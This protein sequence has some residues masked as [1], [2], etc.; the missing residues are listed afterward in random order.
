MD[1]TRALHMCKTLW[2]KVCE[3]WLRS[4]GAPAVLSM[5]AIFPKKRSIG[6]NLQNR[7]PP[8]KQTPLTQSAY[9]LLCVVHLQVGH[10]VASSPLPWGCLSDG[11][12]DTA[13][14]HT[15]PL[16]P[17][18]A[19]H[20]LVPDSTFGVDREGDTSA[21]LSVRSGVA[22]DVGKRGGRAA[23]A[24]APNAEGVQSQG[25][26]SGDSFLLQCEDDARL[27]LPRLLVFAVAASTASLRLSAGIRGGADFSVIFQRV[28]PAKVM[29]L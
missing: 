19:E 15:P 23:A 3:A 4:L 27:S 8:S 21:V 1:V 2:F 17:L 18:P 10:T 7:M 26:G 9:A 16:P 13:A 11:F 12:R 28:F 6:G 25:G 20:P 14:A 24:V 22:F 29:C 5:A